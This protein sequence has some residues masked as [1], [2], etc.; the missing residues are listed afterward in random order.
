MT[1]AQRLE[2][3][4][5]QEGYQEGLQKGKK[6][7]SLRIACVLMDIGIDRET[8]IKMIVMSQSKLEQIDD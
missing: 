6:Q 3:E 2:H 1:I 7:A 5:R 8:I 4:A